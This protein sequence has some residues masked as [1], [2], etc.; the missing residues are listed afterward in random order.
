M[1]T[2]PTQS[3]FTLVETLVS[4]VILTMTIVL[5]YYA[6]QRSLSATFSSRDDLIAASLAQEA[7][8]FTRGVRDNNYL[9]DR[10]GAAWMYGFNGSVANCF[11]PNRCTIDATRNTLSQSIVQCPSNNCATRPLWLSSS[12]LYTQRTTS[13]SATKFQRYIQLS[14]VNT[15]PCNLANE[16]EVRVTA[17]VTWFDHGT[18]SVVITDVL[19]NWL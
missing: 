18:H 8:E 11:S 19:T 6:I 4:V 12:S 3:G 13:G 15:S 7:I 5:P 9:A 17:T 1:Q 16:H 10:T 2:K 14:C